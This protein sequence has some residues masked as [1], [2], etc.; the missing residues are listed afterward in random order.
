MTDGSDITD[1]SVNLSAATGIGVN[2][3]A[4]APAVFVPLL[5]EAVCQELENC[6]QQLRQAVRDGRRVHFAMG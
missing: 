5:V 2:G 4:R 6:A 3:F 1:S